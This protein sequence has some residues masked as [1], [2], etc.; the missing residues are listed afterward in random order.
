MG[1]PGKIGVPMMNLVRVKGVPILQQLH[2]EERLLRTS[3]H[4][5]CII[6]DGTNQP[7]IV[8]GVSGYFL[9]LCFIN[10]F[11]INNSFCF[12]FFFFFLHISVLLKFKNWVESC[13]SLSLWHLTCF[14]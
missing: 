14:E 12:C 8:M 6:N 7:A 9:K 11:Y 13:I 3:S 2:L 1:N 10:S 4:N 5:W